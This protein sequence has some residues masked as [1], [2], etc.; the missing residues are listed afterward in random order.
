MLRL[1]TLFPDH[2]NSYRFRYDLQA[3]AS[4]R[5]AYLV[6]IHTVEFI[7]Q[8][9]DTRWLNGLEQAPEKIRRLAEINRILAHRPWLISPQHIQ[10]FLN[11]FEVRGILNRF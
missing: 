7:T 4:H 5:S 8:R 10:V 6:N 1:L 3:A 2:L 11:C 9:G